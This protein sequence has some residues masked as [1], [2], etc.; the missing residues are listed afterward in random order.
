[1][2]EAIHPASNFHV[3]ISIFGDIGGK[4]VLLY[5]IVGEVGEFEAHVL[6]AGHRSV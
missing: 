1:M 4:V 5:E 2:W 6:K 3:D